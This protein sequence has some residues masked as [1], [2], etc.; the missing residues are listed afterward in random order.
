MK[1]YTS[2]GN[3]KVD[4][5]PT[6][7]GIEVTKQTISNNITIAAD[8]NGVSFGSVIVDDGVT[9]T[10]DTGAFWIVT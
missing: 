3:V 1:V 8:E 2:D 10:V 9:V 5:L 7:L 6:V 4:N